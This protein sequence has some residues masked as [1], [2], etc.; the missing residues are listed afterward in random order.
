MQ[1]VQDGSQIEV[2]EDGVLMNKA[3][4][5]QTIED[6]LMV[7]D[8]EDKAILELALNILHRERNLS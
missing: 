7:A 6:T 5:I 4:A 2:Y 8:G 1:I 3:E